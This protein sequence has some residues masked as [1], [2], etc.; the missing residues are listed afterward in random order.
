MGYVYI[1]LGFYV[2]FRTYIN[3]MAVQRFKTHAMLTMCFPL[4]LENALQH[5]AVSSVVILTALLLV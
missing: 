4:T 1:G 5:V 2:I 3:F